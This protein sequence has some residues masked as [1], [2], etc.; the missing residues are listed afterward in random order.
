M[1][2]DGTLLCE[3]PVQ[4][5]LPM[6]YLPALGCAVSWSDRG[7]TIRHPKLGLLLVRLQGACPELPSHLTVQL[8]RYH[9]QLQREGLPPVC[10]S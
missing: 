8:I 6:A 3:G 9:E 5:I 1:S 7:L 4:P 10:L 2:E